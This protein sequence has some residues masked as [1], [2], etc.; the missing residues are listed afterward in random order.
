MFASLTARNFINLILVGGAV[1]GLIGCSK[2][3]FEKGISTKC[4]SDTGACS[5]DETIFISGGMVDILF[6]DDNSGSMSFEQNKI[7]SRFPTF[8][9]KLDDRMLDYRIGITTTDI[10]SAS[11]PPRAINQ[12]GALQN[13][14]LISF[15]N[16]TKFL[17]PNTSGKSNLFLESMARPETLQCEKFIQDSFAAG[18]RQSSAEY[19]QGYYNNCPSGDE[20]GIVAALRAV[21]NNADQFIRDKSHLAIVVISDENERSWGL[22]DA[23]SS[24]ALTSEDQPQ[25][26]I[27]SVANKYPSKSLSVHSIVV[28]SN[29]TACLNAQ[30][31]Q[32]NGLVKGQY[33]TVYE[34]LSKLTG[35]V[36]GNVCDTDYGS[37]MG[38]IGAAIVKQ[39]E[40]FGL[41]CENPI[42]FQVTFIPESARTGYHLEGRRVLF[43]R[44]LDA[45]SKVRFRYGCPKE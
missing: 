41:H 24:Y 10:S 35:G 23:S 44:N 45:S 19:Q 5:F 42:D 36:I 34:Q 15:S 26:L 43:D 14:R 39:V 12:N 8:L 2:G 37:Q 38:E 7:S 28:R 21:N 9:K 18:V 32:M 25:T 17:E 30:N 40:Y 1:V 31:A 6:V 22:T 11:N 29:D 27:N 16:S 3:D 20:R 4:M 33:G 13:G